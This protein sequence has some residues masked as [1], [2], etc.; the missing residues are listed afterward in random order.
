MKKKV[1]ILV[2]CAMLLYSISPAYAI[3]YSGDEDYWYSVCNGR[4]SEDLIASC[5]G[6][7]AYLIQ[8][9]NNVEN[10][11]DSLDEQIADIRGDIDALYDV[12]HDIQ[13]QIEAKDR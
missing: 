8:K 2:I 5:Q 6:F 1:S 13:S 12:L 10:S 7:N 3:D 11:M 4:I 9:A